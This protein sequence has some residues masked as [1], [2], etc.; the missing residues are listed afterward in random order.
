MK[1]RTLPS[2]FNTGR[3]LD[4]EIHPQPNPAKI[5]KQHPATVNCTKEFL[6]QDKEIKSLD[7][8]FEQSC[9][10]PSQTP[11]SVWLWISPH[12]SFVLH[13]YRYQNCFLCF[14]LTWTGESGYFRSEER[15]SG[16]SHARWE[17]ETSRICQVKKATT[18]SSPPCSG[19]SLLKYTLR[20]IF[21]EI[22]ANVAGEAKKYKYWRT[23]NYP[24]LW[25]LCR[26][27]YM[28]TINTNS[29]SA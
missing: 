27:F 29:Y 20:P 13:L 19:N 6:N 15:S 23:P 24:I 9:D 21:P 22:L 11:D 3:N 17:G 8:V 4:E 14:V 28:R 7:L 18:L 12:K 2:I 25:H 16:L 10:N 1:T 26:R 5:C